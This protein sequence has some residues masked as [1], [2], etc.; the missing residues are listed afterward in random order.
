MKT[1][2]VFLLFLLSVEPCFA[3]WAKHE[4]VSVT[5]NLKGHPIEMERSADQEGVVKF[6][7][8]TDSDAGG[9]HKGY[10][11]VTVNKRFPVD[12]LNFRLQ[13]GQWVTYNQLKES[14]E[15]NEKL[16]EVRKIY[17]QNKEPY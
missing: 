12:A 1:P 4:V 15:S 16:A 3:A 8:P 17:R 9:E 2:I 10:F 13:M 14:A 7:I 11:L 5:N 6:H